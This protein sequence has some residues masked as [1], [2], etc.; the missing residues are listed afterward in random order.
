MLKVDKCI[1]AQ[2]APTQRSFQD[3]VVSEKFGVETAGEQMQRWSVHGFRHS[4]QNS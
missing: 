3:K 4:D 1:Y 2:V